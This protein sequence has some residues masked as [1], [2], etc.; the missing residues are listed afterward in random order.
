MMLLLRLGELILGR[1]LIKVIAPKPK[2][3]FKKNIDDEG[4]LSDPIAEKLRQQR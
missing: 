3:K 2:K 1:C 4:D